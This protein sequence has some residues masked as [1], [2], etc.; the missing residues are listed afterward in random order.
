MGSGHPFVNIHFGERVLDHI[1][2]SFA[3]A[4]MG[5]IR[6]AFHQVPLHCISLPEIELGRALSGRE[7]AGLSNIAQ[8][9]VIGLV[10]DGVL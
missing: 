5:V 3:F 7:M 2:S 8:V 4:S 6:H 1:A 10:L 9:L